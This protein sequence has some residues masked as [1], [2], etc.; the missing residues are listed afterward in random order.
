MQ[1]ICQNKV[2][3]IQTFTMPKCPAIKDHISRL[4]RSRRIVRSVFNLYPFVLS[5]VEAKWKSLFEAR[6]YR[7]VPQLLYLA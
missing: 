2:F 4:S 6:L 3:L 5:L 1:Q 7:G